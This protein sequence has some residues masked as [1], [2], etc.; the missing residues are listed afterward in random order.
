MTFADQTLGSF[1]DD[2]A[3]PKPTPGGGSAAALA[4]ALGAALVSMVANLTVG[5]EKYRAVEP[6]MQ[7]I[8]TKSEAL[9]RR[10]LACI[11]EDVAAFDA[12]S[13]AAKL[14]KESEEQKAARSAAI[15]K[16]LINAVEPPMNTVRA[17]VEVLDLC[18]PVAEKGNLQAISD[19]GVGALMAEAGL[20][21]AALNVMINLAWIKDADFVAHTRKELDTL[22]VGRPEL[23]EQVVE[24]VQNKL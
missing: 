1:L 15:Q 8:R 12:Y 7:E 24:L 10:L 18:R 14:P 13:A 22:L 19:A 9:R 16:A 20:R 23:K 5:K 21:A 2:L 4:G 11:D 17:C 3:S 6:E